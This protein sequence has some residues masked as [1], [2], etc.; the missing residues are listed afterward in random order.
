MEE[1]T[2]LQGNTSL[3]SC[4]MGVAITPDALNARRAAAMAGLKC[5]VAILHDSELGQTIL[6]VRN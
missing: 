5:I 3:A 4:G 1:S 2:E 6:L